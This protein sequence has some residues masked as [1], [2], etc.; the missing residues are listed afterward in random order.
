MYGLG[1]D[2]VDWSIWILVGGGSLFIG[3]IIVEFFSAEEDIS[4]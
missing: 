1:I 4:E 2:M 3:N